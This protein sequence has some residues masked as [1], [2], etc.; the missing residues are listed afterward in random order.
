MASPVR[1]DRQISPGT[2]QHRPMAAR[3]Y[4]MWEAES[5]WVRGVD[6]P[7]QRVIIGV[8]YA[9]A[10]VAACMQLSAWGVDAP[11][12]LVVHISGA[13]RGPWQQPGHAVPPRSAMPRPRM[14]V[15]RAGCGDGRRPACAPCVLSRGARA[16]AA[17]R[18]CA[19]HARA[20]GLRRAMQDVQPA[21]PPRGDV[22][23]RV[24][25]S[26][27]LFLG[28]PSSAVPHPLLLPLGPRGMQ[29][30]AD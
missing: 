29:R 19:L 12:S 21:L 7:L 15:G 27:S 17:L 13:G 20:H 4:L 22:M 18:R 14:W 2:G 30:K 8:V 11:P 6:R 1:V 23:L 3:C 24:F 28:A 9:E 16:Q 5:G 26:S 25:L 10:G